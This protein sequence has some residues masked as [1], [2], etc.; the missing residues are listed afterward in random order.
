MTQ[1]DWDFQPPGS[2][3][4]GDHEVPR[5]SDHLAGRRIALLVC[6]GIAAMKTPQLARA[7]R[8][9][10]AEVVAFCSEEALRYVGRDAL[11]WATLGPI[12]TRLTWEAEHLSDSRPFDAYLVAPATYNTLGKAASGIADTVVTAVIASALGRMAEGRTQI[13]VAPTLH[14][15]MHHDVFVKGCRAL[16]DVGVRFIPPRDDYGK[17]N[18]PD[19]D[20]IV[21][22]LCRA[23]SNSSLKGR[24]ILVTSGPVPVPLEGDLRVAHRSRGRLGTSIHEELVLRGADSLLLLTEG[25]ERPPTWLRFEGIASDSAYRE[26]VETRVTEGFEA[27]IFA[28]TMPDYRS[29][30]PE[31]E[32]ILRE[33]PSLSLDRVPPMDVLPRVRALN[34]FLCGVSFTYGE[35]GSPERLLEEARRRLSESAVVIAQSKGTPAPLPSTAWMVTREGEWELSGGADIPRALA[36]HLEAV[37]Q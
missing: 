16:A 19:D 4:L 30:I 12:V 23:L 29:R 20:L 7:L 22:A 5:I 8:R 26:A 13:L 34:P 33:R 18:L 6:G 2:A 37:L 15:S 28:A 21:A 25:A 3:P 35:G 11:E 24:R 31:G 1:F 17:H 10:G 27:G 9:R 14:G 36:D 32:E